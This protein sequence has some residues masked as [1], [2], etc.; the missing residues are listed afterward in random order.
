M[1]DLYKS[2]RKCDKEEVNDDEQPLH[3]DEAIE[4]IKCGWCLTWSGSQSVK[5]I[6]QHVRKSKMHVMA[7]RR[8]LELPQPK[9]SGV[10][11]H[12]SDFYSFKA[13]D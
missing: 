12:L 8:E 13:N 7:R 10:Q 5:V 1:S 9:E 3:I 2:Y 11:M 4:V 6:N